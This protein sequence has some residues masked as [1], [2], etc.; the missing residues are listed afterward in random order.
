MTGK[1]ILYRI[2]K[3]AIDDG[4]ITWCKHFSGV[5]RM[6]F[7]DYPVILV[8]DLKP[9]PAIG[10]M[11]EY[12]IDELSITVLVRG[13]NDNDLTEIDYLNLERDLKDKCKELVKVIFENIKEY[14]D[15]LYADFKKATINDFIISSLPVIACMI[16][17]D[18]KY[19][20]KLN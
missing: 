15:V 14:P 11:L 12:K 9:D 7:A 1:E 10:E 5:V 19:D 4:K 13:L 20:A 6:R 16:P 17:V 8:D 2:V 18:F 3:D